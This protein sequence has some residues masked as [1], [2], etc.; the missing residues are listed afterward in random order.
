MGTRGDAADR[1][2]HI[3]ENHVSQKYI[4]VCTNN[5]RPSHRMGFKIVN[6]Q[7]SWKICPSQDVLLHGNILRRL[8]CLAE[9]HVIVPILMMNGVQPIERLASIDLPA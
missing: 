5:M 6:K 1:K 2:L 9:P 4:H 3:K 8:N 7:H